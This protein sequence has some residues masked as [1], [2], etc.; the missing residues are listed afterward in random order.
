VD[1]LYENLITKPLYSFSM[2]I[3]KYVERSGID[4]LVNVTGSGVDALAGVLRF[5]QRGSIS[6]YILIMALSIV[7]LL[8]SR[9]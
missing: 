1:E 8:L 6:F 3:E 2:V 4:R 9:L 5:L 7:L